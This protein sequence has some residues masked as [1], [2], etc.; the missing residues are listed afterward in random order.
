MN[1][2]TRVSGANGTKR[3]TG[4]G[5]NTG[6]NIDTI[7]AESPAVLTVCSGEDEQGT[8]VNFRLTPYFWTEMATGIPYCVPMGMKVTAITLSSGALATF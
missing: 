7:L 3:I 4:T 5:A 1:V 8:A 2:D 6:L